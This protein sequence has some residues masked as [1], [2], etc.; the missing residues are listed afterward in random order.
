MP[1][2][3]PEVIMAKLEF[4]NRYLDR[5]EEFSNI[6]LTDYLESLNTQSLVERFLQLRFVGEK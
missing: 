5:L 6:S 2:I 1:K 4:V 3:E